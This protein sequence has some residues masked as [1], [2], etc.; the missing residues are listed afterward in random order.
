VLCELVELS[1]VSYGDPAE[2]A[3]GARE[4]VARLDVDLISNLQRQ[5]AA[6]CER[7]VRLDFVDDR[8]AAHDGHH[9][10]PRITIEHQDHAHV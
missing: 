3:A 2:L 9:H 6:D 8:A 10:Q 7:A 1:R 5:L 4:A